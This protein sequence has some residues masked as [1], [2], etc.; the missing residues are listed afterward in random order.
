MIRITSS[1]WEYDTDLPWEY[2]DSDFIGWVDEVF[3]EGYKH[4][5]SPYPTLD[6]ALAIVASANYGMEYY[7]D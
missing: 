4:L 7:N 3:L 6:E 2:S 1:P 5:E